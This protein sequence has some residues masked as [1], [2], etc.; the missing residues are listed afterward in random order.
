MSAFDESR[1]I[2]FTEHAEKR[3]AVRAISRDDAIHVL[4]EPEQGRTG[5]TW[6]PQRV[7]PHA[8]R[9]THSGDDEL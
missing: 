6:I 4:K 3:G 7:G 5:A 9:E 8:G 1:A 2:Q